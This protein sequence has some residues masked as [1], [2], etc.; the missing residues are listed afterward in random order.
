MIEDPIPSESA[1][2]IHN[3]IGSRYDLFEF[4]EG[5]AETFSENTP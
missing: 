1:R 4:Y 3:L 5:R 2:K